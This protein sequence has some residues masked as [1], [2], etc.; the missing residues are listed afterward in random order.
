MVSSIFKH[1]KSIVIMPLKAGIFMISLLEFK[2]FIET[3]PFPA[4]KNPC[5]I[6]TEC[7]IFGSRPYYSARDL[8]TEAI[9]ELLVPNP[10]NPSEIILFIAK[11]GSCC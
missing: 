8:K 4:C 7:N 1:E 6:L 2:G 10:H 9:L 11:T 3:N 5:A